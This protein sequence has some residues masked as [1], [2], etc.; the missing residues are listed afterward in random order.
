MNYYRPFC[1]LLVSAVLLSCKQENSRNAEEN[2]ANSEIAP[3]TESQ[4]ASSSAAVESKN[5]DRKFI[6]TAELKF[7]VKNVAQ[8]TYSI[9][10]TVSKFNGF[11]TSTELRSIVNNTTTTKVSSDSL[12]ETTRFKVENA[13]V[14]RVPNTALDTTLKTIAGQ[15]DY[16]DYRIIKADDVSLQLLSNQLSQKRNAA[17]QQRVTQA[18]QNRGK[19]LG[20]T[21]DAEDRL[22]QSQTESD[23]AQLS[24]RALNDQVSY[25]TVSLYLYQKEAIRH[26]KIANSENEKFRTGLGIRFTDALR[27]GWYMLESLL[28]FLSNL[29]ALLL[30][31]IVGWLLYR[32]FKRPGV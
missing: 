32:K 5:P 3:A 31:A 13:M 29:W 16:L 10:N 2:A 1:V 25:S 28:V 21:L 22:H 11:V 17:N 7:K 30:I 23:D 6:R 19:K 27:N 15:I 9:E 26:E 14:I 20:E 4:M 18:I 8:S 12:I 24:S